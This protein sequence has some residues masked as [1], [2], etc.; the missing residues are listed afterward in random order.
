[1][2]AANLSASTVCIPRPS[3]AACNAFRGFPSRAPWALR[4]ASA[5][6]VRSPMTLRSFSASA[7]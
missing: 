6:L 7:A 3:A 1:M 2:L 4:L 5:A